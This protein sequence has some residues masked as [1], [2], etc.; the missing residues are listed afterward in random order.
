M[1]Y[2]LSKSFGLAIS[3]YL[4]VNKSDSLVYQDLFASSLAMG[5]GTRTTSYTYQAINWYFAV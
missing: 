1:N 3:S 2:M 4:S 5:G